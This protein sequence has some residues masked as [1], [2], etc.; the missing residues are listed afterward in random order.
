MRYTTVVSTGQMAQHLD[1]ADWII[2][3]CRFT[4][5]KT[6]AGKL[7]YQQGH[8]PGARYVHLDDDMS[9]AVTPTSGRHPLPDAKIFADK[10]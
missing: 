4:L 6:D 1:D 8:I 7:A 2:F 9:S 10:L 3:D 5:T